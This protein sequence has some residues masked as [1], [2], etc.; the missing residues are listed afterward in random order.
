MAYFSDVFNYRELDLY[1]KLNTIHLQERLLL[2]DHQLHCSPV[3]P[4][5]NSCLSL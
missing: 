5:E 4:E 3:K 1:L 2:T